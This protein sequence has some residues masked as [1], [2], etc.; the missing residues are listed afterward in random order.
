VRR[1]MARKCLRRRGSFRFARA[2][3]AGVGYEWVTHLLLFVPTT[4]RTGAEYI[5]A[6]DWHKLW[7]DSSRCAVPAPKI[8]RLKALYQVPD[9]IKGKAVVDFSIFPDRDFQQAVTELN[10]IKL[11]SDSINFRRLAA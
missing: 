6:A 10:G 9:L 7:G 3:V 4:V 8:V 5:T 11:F 2:E 1:M